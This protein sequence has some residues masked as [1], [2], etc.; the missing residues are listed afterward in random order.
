MK[1]ILYTTLALAISMLLF[2]ACGNDASLQKYIVEKQNDNDFITL[3]I[4]SSLILTE[5][6]N[7]DEEQLKS[8]KSIKKVNVLALQI[9]D[10]N[11]E[12]YESEKQRVHTILSDDKYETLMKYGS[13]DMGAT[14]LFT[15]DVE[16][17]DEIIIFASDKAKGFGL[18]RVIGE[19]MNPSQIVK[20]MDK[21][22]SNSF[23]F[24][25]MSEMGSLM[26]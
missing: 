11:K 13:N 17:I 21:V 22:N 18:F 14:L 26:N 24:S 6:N 9:K 15:G 23:D 12:L 10:D 7:L 20:L 16:A 25:F 8:V 2:S 3:D 19:D 1:S 5:N 4:P